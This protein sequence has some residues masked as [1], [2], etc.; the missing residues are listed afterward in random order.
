MFGYHDSNRCAFDLWAP[1]SYH[2][3]ENADAIQ[4]GYGIWEDTP[5]ECTIDNR[6]FSSYCYHSQ[7][8]EDAITA[9][10][11]GIDS[12][13]CDTEMTDDDMKYIENEV[14]K[15]YGINIHLS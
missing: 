13:D 2:N 15:R 6:A 3:C 9:I 12:L 10:G 11:N 8:I 1:E 7:E 14:A 5:Y 4:R